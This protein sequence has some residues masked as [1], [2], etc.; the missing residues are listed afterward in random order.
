[1]IST[2]MK[3]K[4]KNYYTVQFLQTYSKPCSIHTV[5]TDSANLFFPW[6]KSRTSILHRQRK[7]TFNLP[8]QTTNFPGRSEKE[9]GS[10][11]HPRPPTISDKRKTNCTCQ[12]GNLLRCV[13]WNR[14]ELQRLLNRI[15]RAKSTLAVINKSEMSGG[16]G[17]KLTALPVWFAFANNKCN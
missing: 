3:K 1:M 6:Q 16:A 10:E 5:W 2:E 7:R 13:Y 12:V 9:S 8:L 11:F 4:K 15:S 17:G 14:H